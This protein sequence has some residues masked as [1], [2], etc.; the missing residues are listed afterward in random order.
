VYRHLDNTATLKS[1]H[2]VNLHIWAYQ[3]NTFRLLVLEYMQWHY[4]YHC[5]ILAYKKTHQITLSNNIFKELR[6]LD[7]PSTYAILIG[8]LLCS[9]FRKFLR[10]YYAVQIF[11]F[12]CSVSCHLELSWQSLDEIQ[13]KHG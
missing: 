7:L 2:S 12:I 11:S 13:V 3:Q 8:Q 4:F 6:N 10:K 9:K 5:D 1:S